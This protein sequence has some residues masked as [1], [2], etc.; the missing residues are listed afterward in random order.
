MRALRVMRA[1]LVAALPPPVRKASGFPSSQRLF[2]R[3]RRP[4][5]SLSL[6]KVASESRRLSVREAAEPQSNW[7]SI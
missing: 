4:R 3:L 6:F 2:W 5:R 7:F 1:L